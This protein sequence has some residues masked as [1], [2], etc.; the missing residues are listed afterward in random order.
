MIELTYTDEEIKKLNYQRYNHPHP[1]V[2]QR[3][4][5]I[6]LK[7]LNLLSHE[8]IAKIASV[9]PNTMRSYFKLYQLGGIERL[10]ELNFYSPVSE[11]VEHKDTIENH[12]RKHPPSTISE[13]SDI[14]EKL[15]GIKR[16]PT[17]TRKFLKN[18]GMTIRKVGQIPAKAMTDEK[19]KEQKEFKENKLEPRISEAEKGLRKLFFVD[20]AH[21]VW[22]GFLGYVWCFVRLFLPTP[23]GRQRYN[24]LGA[25]DAITHE[26]IALCNE[27]YINAESVCLL[28]YQIKNQ[29]YNV[30]ITLVLDNARYQYCELVKNIAKEL[31]IE[32]LYL[33]SYS[34]NLNIIERLWKWIKKDCLYSKY[35]EKFRD[36]KNAIKKSL[37]KVSDP[38]YKKELDS[39]LK[40]KFQTFKNTQIMSA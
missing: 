14:I 6:Y 29:N 25:L 19:K 39:L 22:G 13:A 5:V 1:R 18:I 7:S 34:P 27:G 32:L 21:F 17:Q 16:G 12:L 28:L 10:K 36:F 11:L 2:Q 40:L 26:L 23:S 31:G 30:P 33:P 9:S 38:K 35:Y 24:V 37:L 4:E 20:A 15:T 8:M 3:M